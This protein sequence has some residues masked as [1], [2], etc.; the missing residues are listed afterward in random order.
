MTGAGPWS[1]CVAMP[2]T[3]RPRAGEEIT[4]AA[5]PDPGTPWLVTDKAGA[6]MAWVNL[7]GLYSGGDGGRHPGGLIC[8]TRGVLADAICLTPRGTVVF[9]Q[10]R[11]AVT[12]T[13]RDV[14]CLH[15]LEAGR[16]CR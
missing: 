8:V 16:R 7:D 6:P 5:G 13:A 14:R 11:S 9:S 3:G 15:S 12:L 4:A 1:W 2:A 10:G